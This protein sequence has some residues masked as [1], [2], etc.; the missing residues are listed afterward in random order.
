MGTPGSPGSD[1]DDIVRAVAEADRRLRA[2]RYVRDL[3]VGSTLILC[4]ALLL[5][6]VAHVVP[7]AP[8]IPLWFA[9][10]GIPAFAARRAWTLARGRSP[11]RAAAVLDRRAS[12]RDELVSAHWF[13]GRDES[14]P[15]LDL[16]VHR[17]AVA[18]RRLDLAGLL[19]IA[20]S[21]RAAAAAVT[22]LAL[23]VLVTLVPVDRTRAWVRGAATVGLTETE[24]AQLDTIARALAND[25]TRSAERAALKAR[26][27]ELLRKLREGNL[28]PEETLALVGELRQL[29]GAASSGADTGAVL[30]RTGAALAGAD[31]ADAVGGALRAGKLDEASRRM[32]ELAASIEDAMRRGAVPAGL[33]TALTRAARQ[34]QGSLDELAGDLADAATEI[35]RRR[36]EDARAA[37]DRAAGEIEEV[38]EGQEF[39]ESLRTASRQIDQ[40]MESLGSRFGGPRQAGQA[41]QSGER[42]MFPSS[43]TSAEGAERM[44]GEG[45]GRPVPGASQEQQG[46]MVAS[47]DRP[48]SSAPGPLGAPSIAAVGASVKIDVTRRREVLPVEP[49]PGEEPRERLRDEDTRATRA[50]VEYRTVESV[51]PY[52]EAD[53]LTPA[54]V[55]WPYRDLVK[56]YFRLI[57]PRGVKEEGGTR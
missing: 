14:S 39:E 18:A 12:L 5:Q 54:E 11:A 23:F 57:G 55:P 33:Q 36:A 25:T 29:I 24:Q 49:P 6:I 8:A 42:Q 45:A 9:A 21:R 2:A 22:V 30:A 7:V 32:R 52:A 48:G 51:P 15:S 27:A 20:V 10:L 1:R 16:H 47:A 40:L 43:D 31:A 3:V 41:A 26:V 19:P 37:L 53:R 35:G 44:P 46:A 50:A 17:A 34:S 13:T 4:S 56:S 38:A 28:S